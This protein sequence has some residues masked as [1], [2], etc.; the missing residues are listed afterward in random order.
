M[1]HTAG[2]PSMNSKPLKSIVMALIVAVLAGCA[3][4][5]D[6]QKWAAVAA[7]AAVGA[8]A[9]AAARNSGGGGLPGAT[10]YDWD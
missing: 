5:E 8:I 7:V 6:R 9:Y 3:T 1:R 4:P 10:D 2:A